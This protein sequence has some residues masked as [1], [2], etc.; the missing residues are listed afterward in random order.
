M[1][2]ATILEQKEEK[3]FNQMKKAIIDEISTKNPLLVRDFFQKGSYTP[4]FCYLTS[5]VAW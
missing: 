5:G 4:S 2:R 1:L 3:E